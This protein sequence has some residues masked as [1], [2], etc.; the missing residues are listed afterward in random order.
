MLLHGELAAIVWESFSNKLQ[1]RHEDSVLIRYLRWSSRG[2]KNSRY[3]FSCFLLPILICW[4]LWRARNSSRYEGVAVSS[5]RTIEKV[6]QD[7]Y[8]LFSLFKPR[9]GDSLAKTEMLRS[10]GMAYVNTPR[11]DAR[12]VYW[13]TPA[14]G[15]LKLNVDGASKGNPGFLSLFDLLITGLEEVPYPTSALAICAMKV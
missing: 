1:I 15:L 2:K 4:H 5:Y 8:D 3:G 11:S 6:R 12:L 13:M 9:A 10:A 14:N 7:W